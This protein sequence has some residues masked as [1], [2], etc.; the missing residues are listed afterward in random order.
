MAKHP[1]A[2]NGK[3][4]M[5]LEM[6]SISSLSRL[7]FLVILRKIPWLQEDHVSFF[8]GEVQVIDNIKI[9]ICTINL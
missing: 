6:I 8:T 3:V 1:M 9:R 2:N 4:P 5:S 7:R